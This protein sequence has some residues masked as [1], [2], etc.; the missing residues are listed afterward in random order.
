MI[1]LG[2]FGFIK[3]YDEI[4]R[5]GF[6]YAELDMPEIEALSDEELDRFC[7]HVKETGF[8]IPN[9]A[10]ILPIT[11]PTFFVPGFQVSSLESYVASSCAKC[12]KVGIKTILFGNGKARWLIDEDSLSREQVFVD[13]MRML[14]DTAAGQGQQILIEPLGPKYSNYMNTVPEAVRVIEKVNRPN[15]FV[16]ADLR[17]F[18]WSGE[19]FEDV[20]KY[21]DIVKH[22][23]ADFPLSWPERRWPKLGDGYNYQA[24]FDQLADYDGTLTIEADVP[25]DWQA[26]GKVAR[27]LLTTCMSRFPL[28]AA[29]PKP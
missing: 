23:H 13:F 2:G 20:V 7:A 8:E 15:L 10:R 21:R 28:K 5:A 12:A 3:D 25:D 1:R 6:D 11:E 19:S 26:A 16:M 9:G 17:H 4:R 24:F 29:A 18:V 22:I 27:E 14:C